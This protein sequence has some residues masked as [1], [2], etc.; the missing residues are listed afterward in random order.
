M[1]ARLQNLLR[2]SFG[3]ARRP[4]PEALSRI[5][6]YVRDALALPP[7]ATLA[8]NEIA[9]TDPSCP[10]I[11]TVILVMRPGERTR[12]YK[13]AKAMTEV[14]EPELRDALALPPE[15]T[16]AVNE[17]ACTDPSCPGIET[18]ILVMRPGERTRAYKVAKP[19][20]TVTE[21]ELRAAL[22]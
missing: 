3:G 9:C 8:V 4:E 14:T 18:V 20:D 1:G 16:L 10:G 7:E 2:F 21:P 19:F 6:A 22:V 17:I 15:A 5:K 12:A 11:E 13:V